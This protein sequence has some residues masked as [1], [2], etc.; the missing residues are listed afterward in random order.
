MGNWHIDSL[1][2]QAGRILEQTSTRLIINLPPR[3]LKSM[4]FSVAP[5][6]L[7]GRY[8]TRWMICASYSD[9]IAAKLANDFRTLLNAA[10]YAQVFGALDLIKTMETET[11]TAA[12]GF[13]LTTSVGGSLTGR[14]GDLI[15]I[16]DPLNASEAAS[17]ASRERVNEW[18]TTAVLSRLDDQRRGII[19]VVMQRLHVDDLSGVLLAHGGR[20]DAESSSAYA[21]EVVKN[22]TGAAS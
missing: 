5:A 16:D 9:A 8:P 21:S 12:G 11:A 19:V 14:G 10:W 18:F 7:L 13:R 17:T 3:M 1:N 20:P 2:H 15:I 22:A 4:I 6:Y